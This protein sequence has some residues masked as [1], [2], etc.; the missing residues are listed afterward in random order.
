MHFVDMLKH[1]GPVYGWWLFAFE[2]F[3]GMM[4]KIMQA[5]EKEFGAEIRKQ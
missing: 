2:R 5:V 4:E 1:F 3:N